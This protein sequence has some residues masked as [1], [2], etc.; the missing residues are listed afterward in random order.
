MTTRNKDNT[1]Y[2]LHGRPYDPNARRNM[3]GQATNKDSWEYQEALARQN[4][5]GEEEDD[6]CSWFRR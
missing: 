4:R 2:D 6:D 1:R 3:F 5:D